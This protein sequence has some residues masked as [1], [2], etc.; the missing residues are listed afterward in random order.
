M[1]TLL[2]DQPLLSSFDTSACGST[3]VVP[4]PFV[5]TSGA[6]HDLA[7]RELVPS[8]LLLMTHSRLLWF[9]VESLSTSLLLEE[10]DSRFRGAFAADHGRSLVTLAT[11]GT[12]PPFR[13][14]LFIEV[15]LSTGDVLR[16]VQAE[17]TFDGHEAVRYGDR[18]YVV[19]TGSGAI[20][21]YDV[22]SL[23]L[24]RRHALWRRRDHINTV[25]LTPSTMLVLLHG[26]RRAPSEV[27]IVERSG[28]MS[29]GRL[30][31]VG[32]SSHGLAYWRGELLT[33]D[34]DGGIAV[35]GGVA[36]FGLSPPQRRLL[37]K[38]VNSTLVALELAS[39]A[40]LWRR[41]LP[42]H[43]LLNL[44]AHP[45]YLSALAPPGTIPLAAKAMRRG[46]A[47]RAMP[48]TERIVSL[49][50]VDVTELRALT[51]DLWGGSH[52]WLHLFPGLPNYGKTQ[53]WRVL[54]PA[55]RRFSAALL[56][57]LDELFG[58]RLGLG[59]EYRNRL[60]RVQMNRM[61]R[62]ADIARHQDRG[63]YA[64]TAHRYHIPVLIPKCIRF[65]HV[66][67]R[68]EGEAGQEAW[69]EIPFKEGEAFEVNNRIPHRVTQTGPYERVTLIV[70]L[71][72]G[73]VDATVDI[74]PGCASWFDAACY[75]GGT[76]ASRNAS[77]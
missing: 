3:S 28:H 67:Q 66:R 35:H 73:P 61:P 30:P 68:A 31:A 7:P 63:F 10:R 54:F 77:L 47:P 34:S 19:S 1:A 17:A 75:K 58:R 44:I 48:A 36:Y 56:P 65:S 23:A 9:D 72:D 12:G 2:A 29:A 55:W 32:N 38:R 71:L 5:S 22:G 39:G 64:T 6:A 27:Q 69:Q 53:R 57:L 52:S 51:A 60:L 45:S 24:V 20:N 15:A 70:D 4:D 74:E 76:A 8:R 59:P 26:L 14:S 11:P 21:V 62:G 40:E 50:P 42:T 37:R 33:L 16:R 46:A 43:G 25:A 13:E 41:P 49:G 18:V